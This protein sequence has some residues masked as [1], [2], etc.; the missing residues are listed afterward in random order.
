[1]CG[2]VG[3]TNIDQKITKERSYSLITDMSNTLINRGPDDMGTWVN[4]DNTIAL[5][6]RRLAI[7]DLSPTG[8]QPM[9][10]NDQRYSIVFNGEVRFPYLL[11]VKVKLDYR[12][13]LL[14]LDKIVASGEASMYQHTG[15][16]TM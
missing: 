15:A 4:E 2:I 5:G 6:F 11:G 10:S 9:M 1:M 16:I 14:L 12:D 3:F 13:D 8:H 7:I